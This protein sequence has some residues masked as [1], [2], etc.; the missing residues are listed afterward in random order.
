[1]APSQCGNLSLPDTPAPPPGLLARPHPAFDSL[2][3][4]VQD[5]LDEAGATGGVTVIEL[6]GNQPQSWSLDGDEKFPAASTYKLPVLM[7]ESQELASG[8]EQARDLLCYQ[9]GDRED[10]WYAD[11]EDGDCYS[12]MELMR[13]VGQDSDN[14]AAHILVRYEGGAEALNDYAASHGAA[15]SAFYDPNTT[16]SNDL[17][18]LMSDEAGGRA[19]GAAAQAYLYPLLTHTAFEDGIPAG[20]PDNVTVV[21]KIGTL[22]DEVNDVAL[23]QSGPAGAYVLA[24]CAQGLSGDDGWKLLADISRT[25]WRYESTR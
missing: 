22:G 17:G 9:D 13:R 24:I 19:G 15:E 2:K 4:S 3:A 1:M 21:H 18:R 7:L 5:L 25:V 20:V 6:G 10:G 23:V 11:Y 16:T 8:K 12:R 14:T